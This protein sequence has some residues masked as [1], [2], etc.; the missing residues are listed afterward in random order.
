LALSKK[1]QEYFALT[2]KG[3]VFLLY[4]QKEEYFCFNFNKKN[5]FLLYFQKEEFFPIIVIVKCKDF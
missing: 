5:V 3:R 4:L 2:P 1:K